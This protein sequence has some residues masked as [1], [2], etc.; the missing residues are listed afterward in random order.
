MARKATALCIGSAVLLLVAL[1]LWLRPQPQ[2]PPAA[3][4]PKSWEAKQPT[5]TLVSPDGE[6]EWYLAAAQIQFSEDGRRATV[7][8]LKAKLKAEGEEIAVEAPLA[9]V[10]WVKKDLVFTGPVKVKSK[11][12]SMKAD[13]LMWQAET[14][15]LL[16]QGGIEITTATGK[17]K[18][19]KLLWQ[20]PRGKI[21]VEGGVKLWAT[22]GTGRR[23][24]P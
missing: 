22:S 2:A 24:S 13:S 5:L 20:Q 18:G 16:G 10:D 4:K 7:S 6:L 23:S 19:D 11:D 12:L 9:S 17:L 21:V 14:R 3:K 8:K 15:Q 1:F